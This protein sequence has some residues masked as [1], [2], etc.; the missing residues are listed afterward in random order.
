[1]RPKGSGGAGPA[2]SLPLL[3]DVSHRLRRGA[4][5]PTPRRSQRDPSHYSDTLLRAT[6]LLLVVSLS[7]AASPALENRIAALVSRQIALANVRELV[8]YGPRMGGTAS[9]DRAASA[10]SEKMRA[11]GLAVETI[12]DPPLKVHEETAWAVG[13]PDRL[14]ASAWPY[15]FSPS[16]PSATARLTLQ[17]DEGIPE[18]GASLKGAVVLT[19]GSTREAYARAVTAGAIAL[20][21]DAPGD[22]N[23]YLD[24][25]PTGSLRRM[26][27]GEPSIPV[28]GLSYHDGRLLREALERARATGAAPPQVTVS[29]ATS[30]HEGRPRTVV[31]TLS[32]AGAAADRL[33]LVCAHGDS[34]SGGPGADDNAS[35]VATVLEVARALSGALA[36]GWLPSD[37]PGVK[38]IIWGSEYHSTRAWVGAHADE[39]R[40]LD[41]VINFDQTGTGAERDAVYYEGNDIPWNEK[42]LRT[43]EAVAGDHAGQEG[44][45]RVYTSVP[46]M[47]GTDA[48]IF[49]PRQY[50]GVGLTDRKIASTTVFS[51]AWDKPERKPQTAGWKSK[52]WPEQ[53]DVFIDYSNYYH[54]SG[55]TPANTTDREP[56]NMTRC[57]RLVAL[58]IYRL[59]SA[60]SGAGG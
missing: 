10:L 53:E 29:L 23:R 18:A 59:M 32:G 11:L 15:G 44:L 34:D 43:I 24:W 45:P 52:G 31:G 51:A 30:I 26:T 28:F 1:M 16:L 17:P 39:M 5:H 55:D 60:G 49:L 27:A 48:Y 50:R 46:V 36:A 13:L 4:S 41:V 14:L 56:D 12:E 20:L 54:S 38:F 58:A 19:A 7:C 9:G 42:L 25:A 47:G 35:G 33:V 2:A 21:T 57:A 6:I 8:G 3:D 22:P 37:R 40:R